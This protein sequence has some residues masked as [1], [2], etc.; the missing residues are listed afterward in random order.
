[1][2]DWQAIA[3]AVGLDLPA[4]DLKKTVAPLESFEEAFRLL[5]KDLTPDVE[6]AIAFRPEG[7]DE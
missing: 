2:K 4:Q 3:R 5:V 6:P 7:E 1:V